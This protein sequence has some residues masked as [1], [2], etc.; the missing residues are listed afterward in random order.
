MLLAGSSMITQR[1]SF[2]LHQSIQSHLSIELALLKVLQQRAAS[3]HRSQIFLR[4]I[5]LVSRLGNR[6]CIEFKSF[7]QLEG[8][9]STKIRF[10]LKQ[11]SNHFLAID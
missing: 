8:H 9:G 7:Q 10:L 2:G 11:V 1:Q 3:Q 4:Y 6:L 5:H